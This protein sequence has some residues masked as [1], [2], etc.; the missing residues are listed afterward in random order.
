MRHIFKN[1]ITISLSIG[2]D[3]IRLGHKND[4]PTKSHVILKKEWEQCDMV[5]AS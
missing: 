3:H 1:E 2:H 5:V 4:A